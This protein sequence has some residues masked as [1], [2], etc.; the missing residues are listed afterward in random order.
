MTYAGAQIKDINI[1]KTAGVSNQISLKRAWELMKK[2]EVV[3]LPVTNQF[4]KL[5]GVIVTKDIAT[6]YMDVLDNCVLFHQKRAHS[7]RRLRRRSTVRS[8]PGMSMHIL[9]AEK[10]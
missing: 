3:T 1:R 9:C 4:G 7:T 10:L 6:S 8:T 5:E 2:L